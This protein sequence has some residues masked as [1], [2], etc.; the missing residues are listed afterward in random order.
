[1]TQNQPSNLLSF[2][3]FFVL[4]FSNALL[5]ASSGANPRPNFVL[6]I[7]DD[8]SQSDLGCY[9]N[10]D[11]KTPH[12]DRLA[13]EGIRFTNAY[14]TCSSCSPSRISLI[15]GRYPH[16]TGACELHTPL[17][18]GHFLF[19]EALRTAGYYTVLSG[20]HHMGPNADVAFDVVSP[21]RGPGKQEDWVDLLRS[22]PM[23]QPFFC[24]F[25]SGDAHRKWTINK[26]APRYLP[27]ELEI[28]PFLFDGPRTRQ[29]L[30]DYY[31][32]VSRTDTFAGRVIAELEAQNV[33]DN[34]YVIYISDNG[35]P[36]PRC[37][38]RLYD[39]GL[40][41]P[42]IIHGPNHLNPAVVDALVSINV[43]L[44][45]TLL[46]LAGMSVSERI[47]GVSFAP[48]LVAPSVTT[49]QFVFGE[50]NWHVM[51]ANQRM[52]RHG[53]WVYI[54]NRFP[55]LQALC[56]EASPRFPAGAELWEAERQNRL[57]PRQ[58]DIFLIP[59][60]TD[61]LYNVQLDPDQT[62]NLAGDNHYQETL[63]RLRA[64]LTTWARDTRDELSADPT[65]DRQDVH[66]NRHPNWQHRVQPGV[67]AGSVETNNKGPI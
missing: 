29:D 65:R 39:S 19:P 5:S 48:I 55:E 42:L 23:D 13:T 37:K 36:F 28:P 4:S 35:R 31:H 32:E 2:V 12:L 45:A 46:E 58:Q 47:Q 54:Q 21:G 34:T 44:P 9:G 43:D 14:L 57:L 3:V 63:T 41:S 67:A 61:E 26:D 64:A 52:V 17:P 40:K 24:W 27:D 50:Q 66:G 7:T 16:N 56:V 10:A 18:P 49:R 20:K 53:E 59:R 30:A 11:V 51:Q 22:R 15:T 38:T 1:M 33:L 6:M 62:N 25:A 8:I 60:P